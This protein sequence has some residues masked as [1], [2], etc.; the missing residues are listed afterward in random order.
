[1]MTK[2]KTVLARLDALRIGN[3]GTFAIEHALVMPCLLL[4]LSGAIDLGYA[5]TQSSSLSGAARAGAQF[6]MRFPSDADGIKDVVTKTLDYDP[7]TLTVTSKLACECENG[8]AVA[9]TDT[10][11]GAAPL[12][13]VTVSVSKT[14]ASPLPTAM[15]LGITTLSGSA[16]MRAN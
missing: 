1:M 6:A 3:R 13:F 7:A 4:L 2:L 5:L 10:C 15:M 14:Y 12:A 9:C 11:G 16:V 8:T